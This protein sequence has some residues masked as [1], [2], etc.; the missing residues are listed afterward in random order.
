MQFSKQLLQ[1]VVCLAYSLVWKM[2]AVYFSKTLINFCQT[3]QHRIPED[4]TLL[5]AYSLFFF[6]NLCIN[7]LYYVG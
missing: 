5:Y 2:K 3:T 6:L 7:R 4:N 1:L